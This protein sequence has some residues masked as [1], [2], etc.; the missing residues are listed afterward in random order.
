MI[1]NFPLNK[2]NSEYTAVH[3][4]RNYRY[5]PAADDLH[6]RQ[7]NRDVF[8]YFFFST[9]LAAFISCLTY[10]LSSFLLIANPTWIH[11]ILPNYMSIA[12]SINLVKCILSDSDSLKNKQTNKNQNSYEKKNE[13]ELPSTDDRQWFL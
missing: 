11:T 8:Y 5:S 10:C 4:F 7:L 2:V 1:N 3:R 9:L 6:F 13:T 12:W